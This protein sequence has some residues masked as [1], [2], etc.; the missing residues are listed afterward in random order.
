LAEL[1]LAGKTM[2]TI[3]PPKDQ[4]SVLAEWR[5]AKA[6]IWAFHISLKRIAIILTRKDGFEALYIIGVG[7]EHLSGPFRWDQANITI[8]TE[9]PNQWGEVKCRITDK[10]AGF[11]LLCSSATMARGIGGP[12]VDPFTNFL[13]NEPGTAG[14]R[15][16]SRMNKI[17]ALNGVIQACSRS[18]R[19]TRVELVNGAWDY[20]KRL[21]SEGE[22]LETMR[23]LLRREHAEVLAQA[24]SE[25]LA[26]FQPDELGFYS[27]GSQA[28]PETLVTREFISA[29]SK[30]SSKRI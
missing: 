24:A 23:K 12:P 11:E 28:S 17:A 26:S 30:I 21:G 13:G 8:T 18:D 1:F 7:C 15:D 4:E 3:I 22:G 27:A 5:G 10:E 25:V 29:L 14:H 19:Y 16:L 9:P 2:K 6:A 20:C